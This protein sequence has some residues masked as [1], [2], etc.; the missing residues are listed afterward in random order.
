MILTTAMQNAL[1]KSSVQP[2]WF[3]WFKA[4]NRITGQYQ[5]DG[6]WTGIEPF[7]LMIDGVARTY[8]GAGGLLSI[9]GITYAAGTNIQSQSIRL[10]VLDPKVFTIIRT[11][12]PK[13]APVQIHLGLVDPQNE[14]LV[15]TVK[16]F[17]GFIDEIKETES[18][19]GSYCE[20]SLVSSMRN[21]SRPL[22]L[23]QSDHYQRLRNANDT[24]RLYASIAGQVTLYWG[25][26][27]DH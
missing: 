8:S 4:R 25:R 18:L 26:R 14:T 20:V 12:E 24:G 5:Q 9:D 27:T 1:S 13:Y 21:G 3:V 10:T 23:K 11:Y 22:Y 7:S 2:Y 16:A 17:D 6:L 19:D 15:G